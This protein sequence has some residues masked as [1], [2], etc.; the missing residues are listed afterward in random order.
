MNKCWL[1]LKFITKKAKLVSNMWKT[2]SNFGKIF[3]WHEILTSSRESICFLETFFL[4]RK[5]SGKLTFSRKIWANACGRM[6]NR[7]FLLN[8]IIFAKTER[9]RWFCEKWVLMDDFAKIYFSRKRNFAKMEKVFTFQPY[10]QPLH[11]KVG[12]LLKL[13]LTRRFLFSNYL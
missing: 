10:C 13:Q 6:K 1:F 3:G 11:R 5:I 4:S 8:L 12:Q 7:Q 2:G 9:V